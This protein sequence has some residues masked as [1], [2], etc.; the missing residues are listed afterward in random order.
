MLVNLLYLSAGAVLGAAARFAF[1][2][3]SSK[4]SQHHGF[5][6]GTLLV[7]VTGCFIVGYVLTWFRDPVHDRWRIFAATGFC[8]SF[9]TFSAF[10]YETVAYWHGGQRLEFVAN[11]LLNNV[12]CLLAVIA[13]I[14][15]R[16]GHAG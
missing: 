9:T 5:P 8:G 12:L 2:H 14:G 15:A 10:G 13:G 1:T 7:N 4:L 3:W 11:I 16:N 6:F